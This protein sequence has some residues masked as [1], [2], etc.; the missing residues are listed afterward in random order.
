MFRC[1]EVEFLK[2]MIAAKLIPLS[3]TVK[4]TPKAL[5]IRKPFATLRTNAM[6]M[7]TTRTEK[8]LPEQE[9]LRQSGRPP[10]I[11]ITS[12]TNLIRLQI[13]L[14]EH[15]KREHEFRNTR[16]KTRI[17]H[18]KDVLSQVFLPGEK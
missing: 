17:T 15:I 13:E 11:T 8:I 14:K 16:N 5:P 7:E 9:A 18:K 3:T 2:D 6:D 12:T 4:Q 1:P 10:P